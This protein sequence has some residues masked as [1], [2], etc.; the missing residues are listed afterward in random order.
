MKV[1]VDITKKAKIFHSSPFVQLYD[2]QT[3]PGEFNNVG[4]DPAYAGVRKKM[5]GALREWMKSV[6]D[7]LLEGPLRTP[8]YDQASSFLKEKT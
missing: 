5:L 2:L 1:P 3:D 4:E 6:D 7:P 8:Y